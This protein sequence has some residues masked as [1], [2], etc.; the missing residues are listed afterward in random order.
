MSNKNK[1]AKPKAGPPTQSYLDIAE[2]RD[3]C[4][5]MKDGTMRA[6][7]IC[8]S[9]NFS[10][11]SEDEQNAVI[12]AY[13]GFLN[14]LEWPVQIAIQSR[15]LNIDG[16]IEKLN[17]LT[18]QQPNELLRVMTDDYTSYIKELVTLG[19]IMTKR[20]LVVVPY[21]SLSDKRSN[22]WRRLKNVLSLSKSIKLSRDTFAK[23]KETLDRRVDFIDSALTSMSLK[24][25]RLDTQGLIELYYNAYNPELQE[26]EKLAELDKLQVEM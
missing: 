13:I 26:T 10:L 9:I 3:D 15:R 11:K 5:I 18:K 14:S 17:G 1:L 16:Y 12:Q 2:I 7:I 4:V 19:E 25:I 23:Y 6:V 21:S 24:S 22:F 8:S 20:F